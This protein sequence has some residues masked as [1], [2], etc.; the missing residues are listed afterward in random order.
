[1][2][3]LASTR[4]RKHL[5]RLGTSLKSA[6]SGISTSILRLSNKPRA[7]YS[8]PMD[9]PL[10]G[11]TNEA[12]YRAYLVVEVLRSTGEREFPMQLAS[13]FLWIASHDGCLQEDLPDAISMSPSSVSRNVTWL[14]Q[15]H[16][17]G[18]EGLHLV[19]RRRDTINPK[20][21][22]LFLTRKGVQFVNLIE[23]QLEGLI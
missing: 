12:L 6:S 22:R 11:L 20:R 18:R 13:T 14:G 10:H 17:S 9:A 15:S 19:V 23:K 1:M 8:L 3:K 16:R 2:F 5:Q 7:V 21:W 4:K